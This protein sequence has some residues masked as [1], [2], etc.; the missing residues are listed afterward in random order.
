MVT[1]GKVSEQTILPYPP[2]ALCD[3][4]D[5]S[6]KGRWNQLTQQ[7]QHPSFY[8]LCDSTKETINLQTKTVLT[9]LHHGFFIDKRHTQNQSAGSCH[10]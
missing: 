6:G 3:F 2:T 1:K 5:C 8:P 10:N 9:F 4:I 7:K